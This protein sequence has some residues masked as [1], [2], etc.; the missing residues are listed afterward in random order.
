MI[1][2]YRHIHKLVLKKII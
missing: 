1:R 2:I